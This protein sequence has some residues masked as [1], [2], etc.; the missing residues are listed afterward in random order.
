MANTGQLYEVAKRQRSI[1]VE[2]LQAVADTGYYNGATL[3]E[4][5]EGGIVAY[6]PP[7][8]RTGNLEEQGR[9][10]HEAFDYDA[11]ANVYRCPADA[12]LKPMKGV[13][14]SPAG[15]QDVRYVSLQIRLQDLSPAR[16]ALGQ[17][18]DKRTIPIAGSTKR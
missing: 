2:T 7:P 1:G 15:R 11:K 16:N 9:F 6:V 4:C 12:L 5:E 8:K 18:Q 3:K 10:T 14:T 17:K 13:K